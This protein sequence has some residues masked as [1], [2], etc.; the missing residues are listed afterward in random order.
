MRRN[1]IIVSVSLYPP[2]HEK[3]N[4]LLEYMRENDKQGSINRIDRFFKKFCDSPVFNASEISSYCGYC[5]GL[6]DGH[7]SKCI[8][9][10]TIGY[11]NS[12]YNLNLPET[13]GLDIYDPDISLLELIHQLEQP[14]EL[15]SYCANKITPV[16]LFEWKKVTEKTKKEDVVWKKDD[17]YIHSDMS[18]QF[19][20]RF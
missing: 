13:A 2:L 20:K 1:R 12:K 6:R 4:E 7:I 15:C 8:D 17:L 18:E 5:M 16:E 11:L 9:S 3:L 14:L 10:L 19:L